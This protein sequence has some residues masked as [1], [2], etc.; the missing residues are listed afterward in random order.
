MHSNN[1]ACDW[2]ATHVTHEWVIYTLYTWLSH[3][4]ADLC[5]FRLIHVWDDSSI[6]D[7]THSYVTWP[8]HTK[9]VTLV[10]S[11]C[12]KRYHV[13][14]TWLFIYV[15]RDSS[16]MCDMTLHLCVTWLFIYVWHDSSSM[17]DMTLHLCVTWLLIYVW[18][19]SCKASRDTS[20]HESCHVW[21][22]SRINEWCHMQTSHVAFERVM[23]H[24]TERL[25]TWLIHTWHDPFTRDVTDTLVYNMC[26]LR[27]T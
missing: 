2:S 5:A 25:V 27:L 19:D 13:C 10:P 11:M 26:A 20:M 3:Q 8:V 7:M 16:S 12:A 21:V 15:L 14:V 17:C 22:A 23:S 24:S 6:R 4:I 9:R 18:H 1:R